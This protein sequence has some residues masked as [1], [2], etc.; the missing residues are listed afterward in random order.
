MGP[1]DQAREKIDAL[2]AACGWVVQPYRRVDFSAGRGVAL[3]E[4]PLKAGSCDYLLVADRRPVGIIEAKREGT[5][6]S[7]V[8]EQSA[9]YGAS[10]PDFLDTGEPL[11]FYYESTGVETFFRD[12]RD[13]SPRSRSVFAFHRPET[14][15]EWEEEETTLRRAGRLRQAVLQRAFSG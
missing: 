10:L 14:L 1:E 15:A 13:P 7:T 11:P 6:L 8:A 3:T 12:E 2:L 4:A 5:L 9:Q